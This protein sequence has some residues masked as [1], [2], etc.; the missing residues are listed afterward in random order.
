ML[1]NFIIDPTLPAPFSKV[2]EI[3]FT[4]KPV[5]AKRFLMSAANCFRM[6]HVTTFREESKLTSKIQFPQLS[7]IKPFSVMR[8]IFQSFSDLESAAQ[9][10]RSALEYQ[11]TCAMVQ[12]LVSLVASSFPHRNVGPMLDRD[13]FPHNVNM[14]FLIPVRLSNESFTI[15]L[16]PHSI[17]PHN[18]ILL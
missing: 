15:V 6:L 13:K 3:I 5:S 4:W 2:L 11:K 17:F 14:N 1:T 18:E 9:F 8:S 10:C 7:S 12:A 16:P